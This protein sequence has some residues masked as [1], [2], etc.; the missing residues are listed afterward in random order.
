MG[1]P[2]DVPASAHVFVAFGRRPDRRFEVGGEDGHHLARVLR[3]RAGETVTVADGSGAWRPYRVARSGPRSCLRSPP[4]SLGR[5]SAGAGA[6]A[7][8]GRRL[9]PDQGRTSPSWSY[10]SSPSSASTASSRSWPTARS[11]RP[12]ATRAGRRRTAGAG[13]PGRPPGSAVGPPCPG[14]RNWRRWRPLRAIPAWWWPS[15]VVDPA[16]RLGS[17]PGDE[18]LVVVGPRG[19]AGRL[20]GGGPEAMGP[21]RP[22]PPHP[23]GRDGRSGGRRPPCGRATPL[24]AGS[25]PT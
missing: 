12:D 13:S 5:P 15:G 19:R 3:L 6:V 24:E 9:R 23:P 10:R 16:E 25:P 11:A 22:R 4:R 21:A 8:P 1:W 2:A 14:W 20:R 18:I 7:P 17:P